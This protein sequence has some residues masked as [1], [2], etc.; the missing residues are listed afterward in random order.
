VKF[1]VAGGSGFVGRHVVRRLL[2]EG[3]AVLNADRVP[4]QAPEPGEVV[5]VADLT[6]PEGIAAA[7][8]RGADAVVWLAASIRQAPTIDATAQDDLR[9]MVEA[10]LRLL[11]VLASP[12]ASV[13]YLSSVQ[14]YGR[15]DRLPVDEEHATR[16]FTVYGVAKL[17]AE[18]ML[19]VACAGRGIACASLRAA[20]VYGPGQ[21][22]ANAIPRFLERVRSGVAPVVHGDGAD[23]RDDVFV[24]DVAQAVSH[25]ASRRAH[26][27]LNIG[28]GAPHTLLD[29]ARAT[30]D[31]VP[32]GLRPAH[33]DRPS[34]WIDRWYT[35]D[36]A[37]S[38]LGYV[39][40]AFADG[41]RRQWAEG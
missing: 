27:V 19:G 22:P 4:P 28:S 2:S 21:H 5:A 41:L 13:V 26:G 6:S 17:C 20:F 9:L 25:A 14:V 1:L 33:E 36:R 12:P 30:C 24:G 29:V 8:A 34:G 37:R 31:L 23:V 40:T 15:P 11:S 18:Q 7:A 38:E 39:P 10:P 16:P 32:S 35:I 3:H